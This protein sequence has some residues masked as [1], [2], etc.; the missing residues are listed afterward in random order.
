MREHALDDGCRPP[1][2]VADFAQVLPHIAH[3]LG[4]EPRVAHG[5]GL[6]FFQL[7]QQ[8]GADFGEVVDEVQGVLN[9]VGDAGREFAQA[10]HLF[11][12]NQLR[13]RGAQVGEG[14]LQ[15]AGA[16]GYLVFER[17]VLLG[18]QGLLVLL[19]GDSL[20]REALDFPQLDLQVL[21][22]Q[23]ELA[24]QKQRDAQSRRHI[25]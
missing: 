23:G 20:G 10:G 22:I 12:L 8:F 24:G 16:L 1:P 17:L 3:Q 4:F 15:L 2:V 13:L 5:P 9:L 18:Q 14:A 7:L 19:L 21:T 6:L 11:L 25:D